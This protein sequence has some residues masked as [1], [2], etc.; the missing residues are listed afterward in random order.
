M[1]LHAH[2]SIVPA[3]TAY[4]PYALDSFRRHLLYHCDGE[5]TESQTYRH[6]NR[7][8][9]LLRGGLARMVVAA[10]NG[11]EEALGWAVA[12]GEV[13]VFAYVREQLRRN[14][15]G[16]QMIARLTESVPV[17]VAYWTPS[18][19]EIR[20]AGFPIVFD[21]DA[22]DYVARIGRA[23]PR[24]TNERTTTCEQR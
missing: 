24:T 20:A 2:V 17:R 6:R 13:V 19:A 5:H 3:A 10:P 21:R 7:L 11:Y 22:Y 12:L 1:S 15:L 14:G 8:A 23:R 18:A 4:W 16:S 9:A